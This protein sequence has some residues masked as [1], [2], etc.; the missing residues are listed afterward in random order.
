MDGSEPASSMTNRR[1]H[2]R[3]RALKNALIVFNEGYCSMRCQM[4]EVS[5]GGAKLVPADPLLC[6]AEFMLRPPIGSARHCEVVWRK[7]THIGVTYISE[8]SGRSESGAGDRVAPIYAADTYHERAVLQE[9]VEQLLLTNKN[10]PKSSAFL[11][12]SIINMTEIMNTHGKI[13]GEAILLDVAWRLRA[14]LRSSDMI[15]S[16]SENTLAVVLPS[17]R[18]DGAAVVA[19]KIRALNAQPVTTIY[20]PIDIELDVDYVLFPGDGLTAA[21]VINRSQGETALARYSNIRSR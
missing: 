18:N 4:L 21:D 16:L 5:E 12:V 17:F 20:G 10:R 1:A 6:P 14:C 3:R 11:V 8:V 15:G 7:G 13:I 9:A 19:D 2:P